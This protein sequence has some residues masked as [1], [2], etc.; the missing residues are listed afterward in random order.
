M[1]AVGLILTVTSSKVWHQKQHLLYDLTMWRYSCLI[2]SLV[3]ACFVSVVI[4]G[5]CSACSECKE[6]FFL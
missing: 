6:A 2:R 3:A 5:L 1:N 4:F